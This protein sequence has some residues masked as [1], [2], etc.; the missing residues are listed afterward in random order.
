MLRW[1]HLF[2]AAILQRG[3]DYFRNNKVRSLIRDGEVFYGVVEGTKEYSVTVRTAGDRVIGMDC[4]CPY[5]EDGTYCKHM[6]AVLYEISATEVPMMRAKK[7]KEAEKPLRRLVAPFAQENEENSY[8]YY[9]PSRFTS[10]LEIYSDTYEKAKKLAEGPDIQDFSI[11]QMSGRLRSGTE[12]VLYAEARF[13]NNPYY[14][15]VLY[16]GRDR[17]ERMVCPVRD[18]K[19]YYRSFPDPEHMEIC[20][21]C[22]AMLL[23]AVKEIDRHPEWDG[24]DNGAMYLLRNYWE[25]IRARGTAQTEADGSGSAGRE[26]FLEPRL[27]ESDEGLSLRFRV[28]TADK[29]YVLK[30]PELLVDAVGEGKEFVLGTKSSLNFAADRFAEKDRPWYELIQQAVMEKRRHESQSYGY[31]KKLQGIE[32]YGTRMDGF[33]EL[34]EGSELEYKKADGKK[35]LLTVTA[36][37]PEIVLQ[38]RKNVSED[39]TFHGMTL[40]GKLPEL[41]SGVRYRYCLEEERLCRVDEERGRILEQLSGGAEDGFLQIS[42]GRNFLTDFYRNIIPQLSKLA[43]IEEPDYEEIV[44][45]MP[46]EAGFRFSLDAVDGTPL[47]RAEAVYG[48]ES[49]LL[50]DWLKDRQENLGY[51]DQIQETAVLLRVE[52]Y[53]PEPLEHGEMSADPSEDSVYRVLTEGLDVLYGLGEVLSTS[54]FDSLRVRKGIRIQLGV[55]VDS[56]IM[57]LRIQ[58]DDVTLAEL[59]EILKSYR[60]KKKYHRLKNGDFLR[61]DQ[62]IGELAALTDTL[63]LSEKDLLSG[64]IS[65]PAYRALYLESMLEKTEEIYAQRDRRFRSLIKNF[66]TVK[67]SDFEVPEELGGVLRG[68]QVYGYKW[69]RTLAACGFGGILADEMGLGKTLQVIAVLLAEKLEG[70]IGTSLVVC[71]ASLV[72]NWAEEFHRFAPELTVCPVEGSQTERKEIIEHCARWDVI[73]SS[74]DHLKRDVPYYEGKRFLYEVLDEAQFIKNQATASAKA[75]KVI[76]AG[77]RIALTGTPIENRLSELWSIFDYLMPGFLYRY[78]SFRQEM[79]KPITKDGDEAASARLRTMVGPFILRRLKTEVLKD[80]PEKTEE[81][82]VVRFGEEQQKLYDAQVAHMKQML[83]EESDESFRKSKIQVLAEL[84]KIRQICCD[85]SLLYENYQGGSAKLE[86]CLDLLQSAIGGE[87]RVLLFSQFTSMLEILKKRLSQEGIRYYEITGATPKKERLRL[88]TDFNSGEVPVFLISLRAGGTGLNLTGA[89]IVIH[90][91]PWWN[92][93]A[94]NQATD[95]AHRIGQQK[96]VTVY[97]LLAKDSVEE[98]IAALQEKKL[99][100]ADEIIGGEQV[101]FSSLSREELLA[102]VG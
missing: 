72:Y 58:S 24:T 25:Q 83:R 71:P 49:Y 66:N 33:F 101:S 3:R 54:R 97:K 92:A 65:V 46:P 35:K 30:S 95:R 52:E 85:P 99:N 57:D 69:L 32:L 74:Y 1:Q 31:E 76:G 93:A 14:G 13:R 94:Q 47:C 81:P 29:L 17:V 82:H 26:V 21:H 90:Y 9:L 10:N 34:A 44:S 59:A 41:I 27:E 67:D 11:Q 8:R 68:Y 42:I 38:L 19:N 100:L 96:P 63:R 84:T 78:E 6:A 50:T 18:C 60:L 91:D 61:L 73:I 5:A 80:L 89:D 88:V 37:P 79:E 40:E 22:L 64:E 15:A 12:N 53:F 7:K 36:E 87:H 102:L 70:S 28:G 43:R 20:E 51:R 55:S 86:A 4:E 48:D 16:I 56:D 2:P 98:K 23:L 45:Y 75:V 62:G 39:G 77:H